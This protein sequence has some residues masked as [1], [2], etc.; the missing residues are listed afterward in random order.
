MNEFRFG[1]NH[2]F[3]DIGRRTGQ[4]SGPDQSSSAFR[5]RTR[6][7]IAWGTPAIGILGF[8]GFGDD[9]NS[10]YVNYNYTFQ[11]TDNVSWTHGAHSLKFG[12]DI[13]RDRFSQEGNQ[14]PRS[15]PRLPESGDRLWVCRL[16]ARL[17]VPD[18]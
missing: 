8:S 17:H 1:Y 3:N 12:A 14:F 16:H 13:R 9:S 5:C 10:P 7:P 2:F 11:W 4:R 15:S 6:R 18:Q